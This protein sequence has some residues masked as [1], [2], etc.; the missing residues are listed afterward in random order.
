MHR[1]VLESDLVSRNI[2]NWIDLIFGSKQK[3]DIYKFMLFNLKY[4]NKGEAAD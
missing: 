2:S 1:K 4:S 3:V